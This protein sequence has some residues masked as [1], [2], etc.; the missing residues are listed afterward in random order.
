MST[1]EILLLGVAYLAGSIPFGLILAKLRGVDLR[2]VGS[3]NIG[4]TN[5]LRAV[6][7]K[8][9]ALTLAGDMLKGAFPVLLL[10]SMSG[11]S[12]VA[13]LGG[14]FSVL[15]HDYPVFLGFR[16]GKGVATSLGVILA[17]DPL[18]GGL[19]LLLW[20]LSAFIFRYSSLSALI[21][22]GLLPLDMIIF[23]GRGVGFLLG[24]LLA[25]LIF[26]R[27]GGN[28]QRLLNGTEPRIGQKRGL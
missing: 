11:N 2:S 23:R 17:F 6:G 28:I 24:L 25:V 22:F 21:A 12:K 1:E 7:K 27:H 20:L 18:I 10:L 15:G 26:W 16:G 19:T 8:E 3:G 14:L 9:A 5:V 4:A 13:A